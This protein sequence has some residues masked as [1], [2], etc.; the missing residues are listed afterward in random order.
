MVTVSTMKFSTTKTDIQVSLQKLSKITPTRS[1]IPILSNVLI[2]TDNGSIIMRATDL[3]QTMILT[4]PASI[5]KEGSSVIPVDTLLNIANE[6]PDGRITLSVDKKLNISIKSETGDYDLK[7]MSPEEFPAPP[8]LDKQSPVIFSSELLKLIFKLTSFAISNDDLKPALTGVLFH[9]DQTSL[10]TVS[11]D[12]HRLARYKIQDFDSGGFSGDIIIPKKFLTL[13]KHLIGQ[14]ETV[15]MQVA[16]RY[17]HFDDFGSTFNPKIGISY[18]PTD[19]LM[20]RA[21]WST[22][23]RAPSLTQAGVKLRTTT[24]TFDCGA[25]QAVADLYCEGDGTQVTVNSLELGN[26]QLNAEE[27]E[28]ISLGLNIMKFH[29]SVLLQNGAQG[30]N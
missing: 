18:R 20:L 12:G 2:T 13:S 22:S 24:S 25:N 11:T 23:F 14:T 21:G 30:R 8:E 3:E 5:E 7:G 15:E 1:T 19:A 29:S 28:S 26:S 10:T 4:I 6:L 16:G 17:D 9:F 27:S